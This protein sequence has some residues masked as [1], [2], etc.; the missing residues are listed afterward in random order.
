MKKIFCAIL[1]FCLSWS[2]TSHAVDSD[3]VMQR[4]ARGEIITDGGFEGQEVWGKMVAVINVPP[5]I[6]W[7]L[8]IRTNDWKYYKMPTLA[9]S[10]TV[11]QEIVDALRISE[12]PEKVENFYKVLG[13]QVIDPFSFRRR[14]E[15]W[16]GHFFQYFDLPWPVSNRW[17]I[18]KAQYDERQIAQ[19]SFVCNWEKIAGNIKTSQGSFK[20]SRFQGDKFRTLFVYDVKANTG[21]HVPKFLLKWGLQSTMPGIVQ[22]IR[23]VSEKTYGMPPPMLETNPITPS[24]SGGRP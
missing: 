19:S 12:K 11:N 16:L 2:L 10:H 9:D 20:L 18:V 15:S 14:G 24:K 6:V 1:L 21:S 4:V 3:H 13:K 7:D 23:H 22:A 5:D 17:M 8:F